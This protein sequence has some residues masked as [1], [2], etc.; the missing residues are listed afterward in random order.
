MDC[1]ELMI[2]DWVYHFGHPSK[3]LGVKDIHKS[4]DAIILYGD[5]GFSRKGFEPIPLTAEILTKNGFVQIEDGVVNY[6]LPEG[7]WQNDNAL[8]GI[9]Y[10]DR[11]LFYTFSKDP[12]EDNL[13]NKIYG[14][15]YVHQFQQVLRLCGLTEIADNFKV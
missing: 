3:V 4:H 7:C 5:N 13:I 10:N 14:I 2:G 11:G 6:D 12:E 1:K 15:I 8:C 9:D